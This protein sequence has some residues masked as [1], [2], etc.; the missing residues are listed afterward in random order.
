MEFNKFFLSHSDIDVTNAQLPDRANFPQNMDKI[1]A[2]EDEI[3]DLIKS[4]DP[5][6]ATGPDGI[7]PKLLQEAGH[8]IVP[9]LTRLINLSLDTSRVPKKWKQANVIPIFK[10]GDNAELNNYRPVSLLSCVN[11]I[12]EKL[13]SEI[14]YY[15]ISYCI[16]SQY[17]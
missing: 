16:L 7:T 3:Y 2:N 9:S 8:T 17:L 6:K 11:K 4:I 12:M 14:L 10:K 13:Y 5:S 15:A 1:V